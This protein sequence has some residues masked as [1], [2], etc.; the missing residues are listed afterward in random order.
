MKQL[1][2]ILALLIAFSINAQVNYSNTTTNGNNAS[3]VGLNNDADGDNAFVGGGNSKAQ[4]QNSFAFGNSSEATVT[5]AIALGMST[6][7]NGIAS[8]T[9]G[10]NITA[11]GSNSFVI[12]K[13]I[14]SSYRL[15]NAIPNSIMFGMNATKPTLFISPTYGLDKTGKVAIGNMTDPQAKL[16]IKADDTEDASLLLEASGSNISKLEFGTA[17]NNILA[18]NNGNLEFNTALTFYFKEKYLGI[19]NPNSLA[20]I[21]IGEDWTF[22]Q[23]ERTGRTIA[24]NAY[25]NSES[26]FRIIEGESSHIKFTND[27][28][29]LFE[30]ALSDEPETPIEYDNALLIKEGKVGVKMEP[31][32]ELDV[33]GTIRTINLSADTG[34]ITKFTTE[35][36]NCNEITASVINTENFIVDNTLSV[37]TIYNIENLVMKNFM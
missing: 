27:G 36:I 9:L 4:G 10:N 3:A 29:I 12:G 2:S 24:Y 13:G 20:P 5:D 23:T 15:I 34:N 31:S 11:S 7:S 19:D 8:L 30:T 25:Y 22:N 16:H 14:T 33:N 28:C 37:P 35:E 21:H 18:L 6:K 17:G 32:Y 26:P 1:L